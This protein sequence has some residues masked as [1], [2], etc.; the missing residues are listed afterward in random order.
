MNLLKRSASKDSE[1][2]MVGFI[3]RKVQC[4]FFK[5]VSGEDNSCT[6]EMTA[7]WQ[8]QLS[9]QYCPSTNL[10]KFVMQMSQCCFFVC[11]LTS[12]S[13]FNMRLAQGG[14]TAKLVS[15]EWRQ[16][17]QQVINYSCLSQVNKNPLAASKELNTYLADM[18]KSK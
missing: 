3:V 11:K 9:P 6:A 1:H 14:N 8:K 5:T 15:L 10:M 7:P 2:L 13:I 12:H 18:Q 17:M 4:F 16:R